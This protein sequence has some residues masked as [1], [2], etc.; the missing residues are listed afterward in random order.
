MEA[1][2][3]N[4]AEDLVGRMP[5][6]FDELRGEETASNVA[7]GLLT[8]LHKIVGRMRVRSTVPHIH[9]TLIMFLVV[10]RSS[11]M[12]YVIKC[13]PISELNEEWRR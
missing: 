12:C 7:L 2:G 13:Q 4:E 10:G 6:E 11:I 1:P 8:F 3:P 9:L 5:Q